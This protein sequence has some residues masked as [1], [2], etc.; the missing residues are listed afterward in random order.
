M[1]DN[2]R[3]RVRHLQLEVSWTHPRGKDNHDVKG[4]SH[5]I[6]HTRTGK[7]SRGRCMPSTITAQSRPRT[8]WPA[9]DALIRARGYA[10]ASRRAPSNRSRAAPVY[11]RAV[12]V[13]RGMPSTTGGDDRGQGIARHISISVSWTF[14]PGRRGKERIQGRSSRCCRKF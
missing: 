9:C 12:M 10:P 11:G 3:L 14:V 2:V 6:E 4:L 13:P 5:R 7:A 8:P 1:F